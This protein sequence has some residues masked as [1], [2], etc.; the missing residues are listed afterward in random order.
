MRKTIVAITVAG[1]TAAL[2]AM[3][4]QA[5]GK[6]KVNESFTA[7][8]APFPN[9]S[10]AT[11]TPERSC[12]AGVEGVHKV[13]VEFTAPGKGT[14]TASMEGFTGDWDLAVVL[15]GIY[16]YSVNDQTAGLPPEEEVVLP[17]KPK[18]TVT[19]SACNFAGAPEAE[20]LY[21]GTFK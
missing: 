8:A 4:A 16:F 14:L 9:L 5:R 3:P 17:L 6:K 2:V 11:G 20:V 13:S 19:I 7:Q 12:F 21:G 1:L 18:Q 15:D 10:S